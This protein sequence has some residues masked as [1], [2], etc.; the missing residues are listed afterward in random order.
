MRDQCLGEESP[1][2]AGALAFQPRCRILGRRNIFLP[3]SSKTSASSYSPD[4]TA[5]STI[6]LASENFPGQLSVATSRPLWIYLIV[7]G[8]SPSASRRAGGDSLFSEAAHPSAP[9]PLTFEVGGG[10][11][12]L[13][14]LAGRGRVHARLQAFRGGIVQGFGRGDRTA[15]RQARTPARFSASTPERGRAKKGGGVLS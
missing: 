1:G 2:F 6:S 15:I 12:E 4:A 5:F 11:L 9:R 13:F 14:G 10:L 7:Y 3:W 8:I